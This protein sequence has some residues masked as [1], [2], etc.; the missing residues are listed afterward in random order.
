MSQRSEY[1]AYHTITNNSTGTFNDHGVYQQSVFPGT[2][3]A[4]KYGGFAVRC[5]S[6]DSTHYTLSYNANGGAFSNG[7]PASQ[8]SSIL[9]NGSHV[10]TLSSVIPTKSGY[11]FIGWS[12]VDGIEDAEADLDSGITKIKLDT[13][14][15]SDD[16]IKEAAADLIKKG[17]GQN[18]LGEKL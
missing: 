6:Q 18:C 10:F 2:D 16:D 7:T 13:D 17:N 3:R 1:G 8:T 14:K 4:Y 15:V 12:D 11:T 9:D 5:M